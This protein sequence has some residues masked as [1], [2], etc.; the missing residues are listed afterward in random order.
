MVEIRFFNVGQGSSVLVSLPPKNGGSTQRRYGLIDCNF[1]PK[2]HTDPPPLKYLK[3]KGVNVLEFVVLTHADMDHYLGLG[4]ILEYYSQPGRRFKI[5]LQSLSSDIIRLLSIM[6][7]AA[8]IDISRIKL[9]LAD[10]ELQKIKEYSQKAQPDSGFDSEPMGFAFQQIPLTTD[11]Q[12]MFV[13]PTADMYRRNERRI[14]QNFEQA[15]PYMQRQQRISRLRHRI[16]RNESSIALLLTYEKARILICGDVL[17][18]QWKQI[19]P[20]L[21]KEKK[22]IRSHV[23]SVSHHGGDGNPAELWEH[24][25]PKSASEK[26]YATISCGFGNT[27][28]HPKVNTLNQILS[29]GVTLY[30]VNKGEPCKLFDVKGKDPVDAAVAGLPTSAIQAALNRMGAS[31]DICSG[32]VAY[33]ISEDGTA[34]TVTRE[35]KSVC[36]YAQ[37]NNLTNNY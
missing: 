4:T 3:S 37:K 18:A 11:L 13:S 34:V 7:R 25:S 16:N 22:N 24:L 10:K 20:R 26:S 15:L 1:N 23:I 21:R 32:E 27:Y 30:C 19:L 36:V 35:Q 31:E 14:H 12:A 29:N 17:S 2:L 5:F 33:E 9:S 28:R 6:P 8:T